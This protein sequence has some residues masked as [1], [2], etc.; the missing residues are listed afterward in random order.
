[1]TMRGRLALLTGLAA[2]Y[3]LGTKA[4]RERYEEIRQQFNKLMGTETAQQLQTQVRDVA[5]SATQVVET[6]ASEGIS[7]AGEKAQELAEAAKSKAGST[8]GTDTAGTKGYAGSG[9]P[10]GSTGSSGSTATADSS[11]GSTVKTAPKAGPDDGKSVTL[12]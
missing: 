7:K 2:G 8:S 5:S 4:G 10:S 6:K 11:T 12:P 3:V 1:M 9:G